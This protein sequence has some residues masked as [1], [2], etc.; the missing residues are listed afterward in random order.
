MNLDAWLDY[1]ANQHQQTIDMGLSRTEE[2]VRRLQLQQ[3]APKV[4]VC[5]LISPPSYIVG[6]GSSF[7]PGGGRASPCARG[8]AHGRCLRAGGLDCGL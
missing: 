5:K 7:R 1:I 3:P 8:D 4:V 2:M 6:A